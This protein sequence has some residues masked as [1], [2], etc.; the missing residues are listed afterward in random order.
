[1]HIDPIDGEIRDLIELDCFTA[2]GA[3]GGPVVD[4][5]LSVYGFI[6]AG[7][8][9]PR[10]PRSYAYPA[11]YWAAALIDPLKERR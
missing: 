11:Q 9:D 8:T 7:S 4:S 2:P 1:M 5:A 6:V 10:N 3:S